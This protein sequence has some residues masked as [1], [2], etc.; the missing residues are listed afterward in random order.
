MIAHSFAGNKDFGPAQNLHGA[1]YT[2]DVEFRSPRLHPRNNWVLDIG[3][4]SSIL[5]E[6]CGSLNFSNLDERYPGSATTTEFVCKE[7][8]QGI[9]RGGGREGY[10]KGWFKGGEIKVTIHESHKAWAS[11]TGPA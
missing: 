1:T 11:Y 6:V 4:A 8:H 5:S 9:A 3:E 2:V 10:K 7:I